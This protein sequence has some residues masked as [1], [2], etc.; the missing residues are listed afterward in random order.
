M[1]QENPIDELFRRKLGQTEAP[2]GEELWSRITAARQPEL[3][4]PTYRPYWLWGSLALSSALVLLLWLAL[5]PGET[6]VALGAFPATETDPVRTVSIPTPAFIEQPTT[7]EGQVAAAIRATGSAGAV[8]SSVDNVRKPVSPAP[9]LLPVVRFS[10]ISHS[11]EVEEIM[12]TSIWSAEEASAPVM[13]APAFVEMP[14][15]TPQ[16][17][18]EEESSR[19]FGPHRRRQIEVVDV[20]PTQPFTQGPEDL[21]TLLSWTDKAP[22]CAKFTKDFL[23]FDLELL[24]GP[25]YAHQQ[26]EAKTSESL[27]HLQQRQASEQPVL[28][29]GGG[30]RLSAISRTGL[31]LRM[32][33]HYNQINDRFSYSKGSSMDI[34]TNY[35][36]NGEVLSIDTIFIGADMA[37]VRNEL[38]MIEVPLLL[39]YETQWKRLRL[40]FN[41]GAALNLWFDA[42]GMLSSP[43]SESPIAFGQVGDRDVLPIFETQATA[44][45]LGSLT[46]AYNLHNRWSI[47]AEPYVRSHPRSFSNPAYDLKQNYWQTGLQ[48]GVR[49]RL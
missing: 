31:G 40:G 35:G 19:I 21:R 41:V 39:T 22:S 13:E 26:L 20:L 32:G 24:G 12:P 18:Q 6:E 45:V 48:L 43:V 1:N 36:P 47:V 27:N 34:R 38:K 29:Y 14:K 11:Q 23:R 46:F 44:V 16:L 17:D 30:I 10:E 28:S 3:T 42:S 33:L 49:M 9:A 4:P 2:V 5:R 8:D 37:Q 25:A 7:T 15:S